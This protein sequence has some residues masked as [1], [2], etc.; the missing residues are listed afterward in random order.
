MTSLNERLSAI[1][2]KLADPA[3]YGDAGA[4]KELIDDRAWLRKELDEVEE[5]WLARQTELES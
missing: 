4:L 2:A 5:E 1:E 3:S